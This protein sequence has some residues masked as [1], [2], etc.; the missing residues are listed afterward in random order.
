MQPLT[1]QGFSGTI[2]TL[3]KEMLMENLDYEEI[4]IEYAEKQAIPYEG[5]EGILDRLDEQ[6]E[7]R[8][9][10]E[11]INAVLKRLTN[12]GPYKDIKYDQQAGVYAITRNDNVRTVL[13]AEALDRLFYPSAKRP[14]PRDLHPSS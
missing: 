2:L 14:K 7:I 8:L 5:L 3:F 13:S 4:L 11:R 12:K 9:T 1:N 10:Q 6:V